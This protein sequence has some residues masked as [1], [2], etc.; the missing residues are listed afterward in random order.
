MIRP[1]HHREDPSDEQ[2]SEAGL[3]GKL[4]WSGSSSAIAFDCER[5]QGCLDLV[6]LDAR[7]EAVVDS[8][9]MMV[10]HH[11]TLP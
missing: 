5:G 7:R 9:Y 11:T 8:A 10:D 6:A 1:S 2:P 4:E 3:G